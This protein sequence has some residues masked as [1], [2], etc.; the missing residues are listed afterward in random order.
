MVKQF[1][2]FSYESIHYNVVHDD[3]I[4]I[5]SHSLVRHD[6]IVTTLQCLKGS[7]TIFKVSNTPFS[8]LIYKFERLGWSDRLK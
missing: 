6:I 2:A 3:T 8:F 4:H 7:I 1:I 5:I